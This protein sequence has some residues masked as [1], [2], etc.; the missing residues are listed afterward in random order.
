MAVTENKPE[1]GLLNFFGDHEVVEQ[2]QKL[3]K[4]E[5]MID[6][7]WKAPSFQ[8]SNN[9]FEEKIMK[10]IFKKFLR[11]NCEQI[12][13]KS[14]GDTRRFREM[15]NKLFKVKFYFQSNV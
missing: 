15:G 4:P 1:Q 3:K 11:G 12:F 7:M 6:F 13:G 10:L 14:D 5:Q 2:F 9:A 8:V